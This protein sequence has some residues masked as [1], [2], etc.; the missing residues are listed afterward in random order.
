V[1]DGQGLHWYKVESDSYWILELHSCTY[2]DSSINEGSEVEA[3]FD[4]GSAFI[5]VHSEDFNKLQATWKKHIT[6]L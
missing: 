6:G 2:G 5:Y 4:T 1:S 3:I